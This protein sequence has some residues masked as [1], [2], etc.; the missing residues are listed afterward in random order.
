MRE[1]PL[2]H[3]ATSIRPAVS[4]VAALE[5]IILVVVVFVEIEIERVDWVAVPV[6]V[7]IGVN[8]FVFLRLVV[9]S[10]LLSS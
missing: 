2:L 9:C 1:A 7:S 3:S 4:S 8:H 5:V 10:F 6:L